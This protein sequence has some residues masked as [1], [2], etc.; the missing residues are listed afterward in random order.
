MSKLVPIVNQQGPLP[1][2]ATVEVAS[3][4]PVALVFSGSAWASS[5]EQMIGVELL[6]DGIK[7]GVS[8]IFANYASS[9]MALVS[10]MIPITTTIGP[11]KFQIIALNGNTVSDYNDNYSLSLL[12]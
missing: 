1:I 9:H 4:G 7:V 8:T 6:M 10:M 11:H 12:Y 3:D 2:T 5:A